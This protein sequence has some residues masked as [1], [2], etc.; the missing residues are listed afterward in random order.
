MSSAEE[1]GKTQDPFR[2]LVRIMATL[3]SERGCPWDRA[4]THESLKRYLLEETY[5]ALEAIDSGDPLRLCDELG[6]VLLQVVFHAQ[7]AQEVEH[8]DIDDV[9]AGL[10]RKLYARHPHVFGPATVRDAEQVVDQWESLKRQEEPAGRR[11][12]ALDGVP[13]AL[14][15]LARAEQI[16]RK[17][18]RVGFDW[19]EAAGPL[20]KILEE[21]QEFV[22][23]CRAGTHRDQARE[24]GD[25]LFAIV[26]VCRFLQV[27]A[28]DALRQATGRFER[29]FRRMEEWAAQ[30]HQPLEGLSLAALD[31]LWEQ[32]KAEEK[33]CASTSS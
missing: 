6:D 4:Q 30:A 12:S 29:R 26:N 22:A 21:A 14:P 19:T 23:A 25:L 7:L 5:E 3:R 18:A 11:R 32:A 24:V 8:F 10:V 15:A 16:Q 1:N 27:E 33:P 31:V 13:L 17:A 2:E 20:D 9:C 28:E